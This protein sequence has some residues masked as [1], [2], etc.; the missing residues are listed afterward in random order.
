[1]NLR[2]WLNF[3]HVQ[4]D[5]FPGNKNEIRMIIIPGGFYPVSNNKKNKKK[6]K[7]KEKKKGKEK[8]ENER[9]MK[10]NEWKDE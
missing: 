5:W 10:E 3:D 7:K 6:I 9:K 2:D 8:R 1:M 4:F